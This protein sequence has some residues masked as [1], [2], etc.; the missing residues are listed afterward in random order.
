MR[1]TSSTNAMT[2]VT[3]AKLIVMEFETPKKAKGATR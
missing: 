2:P 3:I 1:V